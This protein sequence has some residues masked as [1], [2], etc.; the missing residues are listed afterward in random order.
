MVLK[1]T[2]QAVTPAISEPL[3]DQVGTP[4]KASHVNV[5]VLITQ[6]NDCTPH[7]IVWVRMLQTASCNA[8]AILPGRCKL[9]IKTYRMRYIFKLE[10]GQGCV[11]AIY[12]MPPQ[13]AV[14]Q[15]HF[16]VMTNFCTAIS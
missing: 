15:M 16:N 1:I 4:I 10:R 11:Q 9:T 14:E 2:C 13:A 6:T 12:I 5:L 8:L 3:T 7:I